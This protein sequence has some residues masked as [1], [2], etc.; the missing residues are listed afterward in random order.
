MIKVFYSLFTLQI[1]VAY[2]TICEG[3]A[4]AKRKKVT[5]IDTASLRKFLLSFLKVHL[6]LIF[7][8]P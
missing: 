1:P 3:T 2:L 7:E 6:S 5:L 8:R 4:L